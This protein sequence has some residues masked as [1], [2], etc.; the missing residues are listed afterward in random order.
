MSRR[1]P[2]QAFNSSAFVLPVHSTFV[3]SSLYGSLK[4]KNIVQHSIPACR[5]PAG[6]RLSE[7]ARENTLKKEDSIWSMDV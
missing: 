5:L 4:R 6:S 3:G 1:T 2:I 7:S